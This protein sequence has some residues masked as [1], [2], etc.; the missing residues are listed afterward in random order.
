MSF[1]RDGYE[2]VPLS[3]YAMSIVRD[4]RHKIEDVLGGALETYHERV[5]GEDL[6]RHARALASVATVPKRIIRS[7]IQYFQWLVGIDLHIQAKPFLRISRPNVKSDNIG[8][9][10]DTWYGDTPYELSVWIPLTD[11]DEGNSLRV[12]PGSHVWSE[13]EHPVERIDG[14]IE[15]GSLKH[16]LGFIHGKPKKLAD[17]PATVALKVKI[18]QMIVF[19]LSLLHGV[20]VNVSTTTRVSMDCRIANSLAPIA[21]SRSRDPNYYERLTVSPVT[22]EALRYEEANK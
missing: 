6:E 3:G 1:P 9:H 7:D 2:I 15:K 4:A 17:L 20:E 11:T 13:K 19:P 14:Q 5:E 16:A 18:G 10:R 22:A 8:L 21:M 12:A